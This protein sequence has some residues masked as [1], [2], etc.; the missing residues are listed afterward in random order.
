MAVGGS[1]DLPV[2]TTAYAL[3][4]APRRI[5]HGLIWLINDFFA[6]AD[7]PLPLERR[8]PGLLFF[9]AW[10]NRSYQCRRKDLVERGGIWYIERNGKAEEPIAE[11]QET[12]LNNCLIRVNGK[13][14][15]APFGEVRCAWAS[16]LDVSMLILRKT[17]DLISIQNLAAL[18]GGVFLA[19]WRYPELDDLPEKLLR[20]RPPRAWLEDHVA[21]CGFLPRRRCSSG[22]SRACT[23]FVILDQLATS[24]IEKPP[25]QFNPADTL[26]YRG[27]E[28]TCLLVDMYDRRLNQLVLLR[29]AFDSCAE[30]IDHVSRGDALSAYANDAAVLSN[31]CFRWSKSRARRNEEMEQERRDGTLCGYYAKHPQTSPV[32][33]RQGKSTSNINTITKTAPKPQPPSTN[34]IPK[35]RPRINSPSSPSSIPSPSSSPSSPRKR[36]P[37]KSSDLHR[38]ISTHSFRRSPS[39]EIHYD[40]LFTQSCALGIEGGSGSGSMQPQ[41]VTSRSAMLAA[42]TPALPLTQ[43]RTQADDGWDTGVDDDDEEEKDDGDPVMHSFNATGEGERSGW[44]DVRLPSATGCT[45]SG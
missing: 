38:P 21:I 4:P 39:P 34:P 12:A 27:R 9:R 1:V 11:G 40:R 33:V 13:L 25:S 7:S 45:Q 22:D 20:P 8:Q 23:E 41:P 18:H 5:W 6:V 32:A 26:V 24:T 3:H 16:V 15:K 14:L 35:K 30:V 28:W 37:A 2:P 19:G 36:A 44:Y 43:T 42:N 31:G 17:T 29:C 10:D